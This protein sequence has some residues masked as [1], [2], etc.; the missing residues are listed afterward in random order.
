[1]ASYTKIKANNKQGYKWICTLEGPPDPVTGKRKQ[2]PRRGDTKGEAFARAQKVLEDL[3]KYGIDSKK[4]KKITFEEVA[5]DWLKTYSKGK[6]KESTVR[7]RSKEIKI[8][9]RYISKIS[10][11][12]ITHKQHQDILNDLDDKGYVRSTIEGVHVTANMVMKYAI[13]NRMRLEN[14]CAGAVIPVK[15]L[16][17]EEIENSTLEDEYLEKNEITEFLHAVYLHGLPMDLER[18]YL[19]VFSGMRSG[20]LC[21]LK[22]SDINFKTHEIRITKTLYNE[23]NNMKLYKLTPPKTK[24]SIRNFSIDDSVTKLLLAYRDRQEKKIHELKKHNPAY[25]D[26]GFLFCREN[27]YPFIQKNL[28]Y[29]MER[30]LK[31]TSIKKQATPHIFRHTHISMLS[32]AGVDLK[33]IMKRVGHDDPETTL[34]IY[35]HVTEKMRKDANEKI[36]IHFSDILNFNFKEQQPIPLQEM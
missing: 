6:V 7:L 11:D 32:E 31:K 18:F 12:K 28:L 22:W 21:A 4:I 34:K 3:T 20:E 36:K 13:K 24:G 10:I 29:R 17:V 9:L 1:M 19:L 33:T 8:L 2:I 5:W 26:A 14:P 23:N 16:T 35:T 27:G 25:H 15:L 30:I